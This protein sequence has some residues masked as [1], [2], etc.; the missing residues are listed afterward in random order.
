MPAAEN[1][2]GP[3][4]GRSGACNMR[5]RKLLTQVACLLY[6]L[7]GGSVVA[8]VAGKALL[9]LVHA[10]QIRRLTP[11]QA[12]LGYPVRICGVI[13]MDA[14]QPDFFLQDATAGIYTEGSESPKYPHVLGQLVEVEGV[15]GP[16][17]FAPVIRE[18]K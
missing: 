7:S 11:E 17:K 5:P 18:T 10:D 9:T 16:G 15:T 4:Q 14:P 2:S 13:T 3:L 1:I 8:Q 6:L 12:A